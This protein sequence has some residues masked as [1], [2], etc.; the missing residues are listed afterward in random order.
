VEAPQASLFCLRADDR[1]ELRQRVGAVLRGER[2]PATGALTLALVSESAAELRE[3]L[4]E[5]ERRLG[6]AGPISEAGRIHF[7]EEPFGPE[8]LTWLFPGQGSQYVGMLASL[9]GVLPGFSEELAARDREASEILGRSLVKSFVN[10]DSTPELE[11]E[12]KATHNAQTGVGLV[13]SALARSLSAHGITPARV[14]GHSYGELPALCHGGAYS[15]AELIRLSAE[16]GR[17]FGSA[18]ERAPGSMLAV[19]AEAEWVEAQLEG[20]PGP[21]VVANL[22]GPRQVVASGTE[23]GIAALAERCEAERVAVT[24]LRTACA[25]HSPLMAPVQTDWERYLAG[26]AEHFAAPRGVMSAVS[27]A[28]YPSEPDAVRETLARQVVSPVRWVEAIEAL[29]ASGARL[30]LEVGPG[31]V[32]STLAKR[33]LAGRPGLALSLDPRRQRHDPRRHLLD[34]LAQL[35]AHGVAFDE[36]AFSRGHERELPAA[37]PPRALPPGSSLADAY[38]ASGRQAVEAFFVQQERWLATLADAPAATRQATLAALLDA[39]QGVLTELLQTQEAG[40]AHFAGQAVD[41][42][43]PPLPSFAA[44]GA[45]PALQAPEPQA[46]GPE[47]L[48]REEICK[49]TGFPPE[50]VKLESELENDLGL[51]SINLAELW[52]VFIEHYPDLQGQAAELGGMRTVADLVT[53]LSRFA[54]AAPTPSS[55]PSAAPPPAEPEA[56][57]EAPLA[58][59]PART[60]PVEVFRQHLM[61]R[62]EVA[63]SELSLDADFEEDLGFDV[64]SRWTAIDSLLADHPG[65]QL[66]GR[67]LLSA[68]TLRQVA[69]LLCKVDPDA[70]DP[71]DQREPV[72]RFVLQDGPPAPPGGDVPGRLLLVAA[73]ALLEP[74]AEALRASGIQVLALGLDAAGWQLEGELYGLEDHAALGSALQRAGLPLATL[75]LALEATPCPLDQDTP[76]GWA[77]R[78]ELASVGALSLARAL[79]P[80]PSTGERALWVVGSS[81]QSPGWSATRGFFR[82]LAREWPRTRI[83]SLWLDHDPQPSEL[84]GCLGVSARTSGQE[85]GLRGAPAELHERVLSASP[86]SEGGEALGLGADSVVILSGGGAGITAELGVGLAERTGAHLVAL[87]RTPAPKSLPYPDVP[88]DDEAELKRRIYSELDAEGAATPVAIGRRFAVLTRQR[89]IADTQARVEAAGGR[90]SYRAVDVSDAQALALTLAEIKAE[91]GPVAGLVHGAG[92][93]ADDMVGR[94]TPAQVRR[95]MG[96][97]AASLFGFH[98]ALA[99]EPLQFVVLLSSLTSHVGRAGQTD[100]DAANE[101]LN[102][103]AAAWQRQATYPVRSLLWSVW[104]E[105]GLAK[106]GLV[107][108]MEAFGL[109][110]IGNRAGVQAFL[111]ELESAAPPEPWVLFSTQ[112][113]LEFA[114]SPPSELPLGGSIRRAD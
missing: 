112:S 51:S 19:A 104:S 56:Q 10:A 78:L 41:L 53:L 113:T 82:S 97:K 99:E 18:A 46:A 65:C 6:Q 81:A 2:P 69:D 59:E 75:F 61:D 50:V 3:L 63:P 109:S 111:D 64:F 85:L 114:I 8:S 55:A 38:F 4:S 58:P 84:P 31:R 107:R 66:L 9:R 62:F 80:D 89:T 108:Q 34:V 94:K 88:L 87:G 70:G 79:G 25:F 17:L 28:P 14:A 101:T 48:L 42:E 105:A 44:P 96:V 73:P 12:L 103:C 52:A 67:E 29:Y 90:F 30:F 37:R 33:I 49:L 1:H 24:R 5:A 57:P 20:L 91:L 47:A 16:R 71:S 77:Q 27:V 60:H 93:T 43:L 100:Y 40:L 74:S 102:A 98:A 36:A 76:T 83:C 21:L 72:L 95:V 7:Q 23:A 26:R 11:D 110:G 32:M 86:L 92:V 106:G 39:N 15:F 54:P 13:S 35:A 45:A 68:R 22:N